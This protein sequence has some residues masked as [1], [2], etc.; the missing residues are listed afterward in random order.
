M[1][2]IAFK[3]ASINGQ[4]AFKKFSVVLNCPIMKKPLVKTVR[5]RSII[6]FQNGIGFRV[7]DFLCFYR[8]DLITD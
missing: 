4:A 5:F 6:K 2:K 1:Y 8:S 7:E 3:D